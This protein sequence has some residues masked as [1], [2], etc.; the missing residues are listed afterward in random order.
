VHTRNNDS[1]TV[2]GE[3]VGAEVTNTDMYG[4]ST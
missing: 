4:T 1:N 2:K 3:E